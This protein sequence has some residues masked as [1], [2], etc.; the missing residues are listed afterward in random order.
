MTLNWPFCLR[1]YL[2][3]SALSLKKF[4]V[5]FS[6]V[7][8]TIKDSK[9]WFLRPFLCCY[10]S[11]GCVALQVW[12]DCNT[13]RKD[14]FRWKKS[15]DWFLVAWVVVRIINLIA[16][17]CDSQFSFSCVGSGMTA[18]HDGRKEGG[19]VKIEL[20]EILMAHLISKSSCM[21]YLQKHWDGWG[22]FVDWW[23][24]GWLAADSKSI[25]IC[26]PDTC[27]PKLRSGRRQWRRC[28]SS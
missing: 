18:A 14:G 15:K 1:E 13:R 25:H 28:N 8:V 12:H 11:V 23:L 4:L 26:T 27:V 6:P 5:S 16:K 2:A 20:A 3:W 10:S 24:A 22:C 19:R 7:F 9:V 21:G 17:W